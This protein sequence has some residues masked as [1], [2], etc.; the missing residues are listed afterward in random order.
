M[1][2]WIVSSSILI[3]IVVGLRFLLRK[4]IKPILQYAL[5][6]LV[7]VRLLVPLQLGSTPISLQNAIENTP[8]VQQM[9]L[10]DEVAHFVYHDDGTAQVT[11]NTIHP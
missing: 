2:Q 4:R 9:E 10:A 8:V 7:L 6:A 11:T 3:L 5:W 1:T